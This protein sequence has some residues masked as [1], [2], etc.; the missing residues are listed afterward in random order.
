MKQLCL[1]LMTILALSSSSCIEHQDKELT[2]SKQTFGSRIIAIDYDSLYGL[3][4]PPA[5]EPFPMYGAFLFGVANQNLPMIY[6]TDH[7]LPENIKK[8]ADVIYKKGDGFTLGID[9]Y[10]NKADKSP[11]PLILIIHGG[12]WKAGDKGEF[13]TQRAIEFVKLGY[14]V[15]SINYRLSTNHKF[16]ANIED[17]RD[18]I[19]F[20]TEHAQEYHI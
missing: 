14:T 6:N 13:Y 5:Y 15:A 7:P 19:I 17:L 18:G 8:S 2:S 3:E 12:Y 4:E 9:I 16:P 11:N 1:V 20:L 10:S